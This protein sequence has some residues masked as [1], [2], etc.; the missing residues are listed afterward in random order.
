LAR[1]SDRADFRQNQF[2]VT[3]WGTSNRE[4][5]GRETSRNEGPSARTIQDGEINEEALTFLKEP[6]A[7]WGRK[8]RRSNKKPCFEGGGRDPRA[9]GLGSGDTKNS[10]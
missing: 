10:F 2:G 1:L 6:A 9:S 7:A 4:G 5:G 8:K 3:K